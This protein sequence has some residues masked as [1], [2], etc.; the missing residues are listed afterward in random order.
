MGYHL[1]SPLRAVY[2]TALLMKILTMESI[3]DLQ[4]L[5]LDS[6][7]SPQNNVGFQST[8]L[9][10]IVDLMLLSV[11]FNFLSFHFSIP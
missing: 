2:L 11:F 4:C 6:E 5:T 10:G 9:K 3:V 1:S 7:L 8:F